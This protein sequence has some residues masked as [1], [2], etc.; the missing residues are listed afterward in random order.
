MEDGPEEGGHGQE[1][2]C[3]GEYWWWCFVVTGA[4]TDI[5]RT[6]LVG[7]SFTALK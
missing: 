2:V 7:A 1:V 6:R 5:V 4:V 3:E